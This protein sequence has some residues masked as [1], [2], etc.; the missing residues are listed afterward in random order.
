MMTKSQAGSIGGNATVK[1]YGRSYMSTLAAKGAKAFHAKYKL[2]KLGTSDF[3]IVY[4]E[5]GEPTGK[6]IRGDVVRGWMP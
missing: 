4:R 1:K 5:S 2:Q 6:T 3:A